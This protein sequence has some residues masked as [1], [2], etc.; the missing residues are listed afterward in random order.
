MIAEFVGFSRIFLLGIS[1]FKWL[2]ARRLYK[3]FGGKG[4]IQ[5]TL[6]TVYSSNL[7]VFY[8]LIGAPQRTVTGI[9]VLGPAVDRRFRFKP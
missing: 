9:S 6:M 5:A 2:T 8:Y 4:L 7:F 3:S 1:V